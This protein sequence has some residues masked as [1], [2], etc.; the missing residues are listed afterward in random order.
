MKSFSSKLGLIFSLSYLTIFFAS[1]AYAIYILVVHTATSEFS[2][3]AMVLT[4]R[5]WSMLLIPLMDK[6]GYILWYEK[7]AGHPAIYGMFGGLGLLLG[8]LINTVIFY[9]IGKFLESGPSK[10]RNSV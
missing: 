9:F 3:L 1:W 4:T 2:G 10:K 5:P 7:F 6:V 8:A